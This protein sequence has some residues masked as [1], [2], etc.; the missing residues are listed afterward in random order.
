[1]RDIIQFQRIS[2]GWQFIYISPET[3]DTY[4][5]FGHTATEARAKLFRILGW[6]DYRFN[7][8]EFRRF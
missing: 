4:H 6:T 5:A 3:E 1:M 2:G 7:R 8:A